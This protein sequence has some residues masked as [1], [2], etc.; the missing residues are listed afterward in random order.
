[1]LPPLSKNSN[2]MGLGLLTSLHN[3]SCHMRARVVH[4]HTCLWQI[5]CYCFCYFVR[6]LCNK[7]IA[8]NF[9]L[10]FITSYTTETINLLISVA[11]RAV[12][13]F[14][15]KKLPLC[16]GSARCIKDHV[17][18]DRSVIHFGYSS[19]NDHAFVH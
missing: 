2:K 1:M 19:N 3:V 14:F 15:E 11:P 6:Y 9:H 16:W 10:H 8:R 17:C 7:L 5:W 13:L 18:R 12:K 4:A